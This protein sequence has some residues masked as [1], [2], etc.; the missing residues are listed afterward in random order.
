MSDFKQIELE[1]VYIT[2]PADY[3]CVYHR[4]LSL[5]ADYGMD[6]LQDCKASCS[7]K[8]SGVIECFNMFNSAVAAR[9]LGNDKL[10]ELLI[11]YI[12]AKL[13]QLYKNKDNSTSFIFPVDETGHLKAIVSCGERPK[14]EIDSSNGELL[15]H[16]FNNGF[17]EHFSLSTEDIEPEYDTP[18]NITEDNINEG[19]YAEMNPRY[20]VI[21]GIATACADMNFYYNGRKLKASAVTID[22][23]FDNE[24]VSSFLTCT[25]IQINT[26]HNF[27]IVAHYKGF[28]DVVTKDLL[29]EITD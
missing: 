2:I 25:N 16:K 26:I 4:I 18:I 11:K 15:E 8:N 28:V 9:K 13:N 3:I 10:A 17:N 21:D 22:Y 19:F 1:Y 12:K 6:M 20:D 5:L 23:Y 24:Q 29:Y 7:D 14:F 27:M